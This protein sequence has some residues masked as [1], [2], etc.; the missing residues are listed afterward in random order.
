MLCVAHTFLHWPLTLTYHL[1]F[2]FPVSYGHDLYAYRSKIKGHL[3]QKKYSE[4]TRT[5]RWSHI[6]YKANTIRRQPTLIYHCLP[7]ALPSVKRRSVRLSDQDI[8]DCPSIDLKNNRLFARMIND[9]ARR[10]AFILHESRKNC[11]CHF[12][13]S[14]S[15]ATSLGRMIDCLVCTA[16]KPNTLW[17]RT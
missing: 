13:V 6:T 1:D 11:C 8:D 14:N 10:F 16:G 9:R 15:D 4:N 17:T 7:S 5:D 3:V 12:R 2:Q